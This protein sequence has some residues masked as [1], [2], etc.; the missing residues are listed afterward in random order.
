MCVA[1]VG[2]GDGELRCNRVATWV[3]VVCSL[4]GYVLSPLQ[5]AETE[6]V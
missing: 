1:M 2:L 3:H 5:R 6:G 4:L